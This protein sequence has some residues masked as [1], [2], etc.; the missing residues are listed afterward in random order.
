LQ[1]WQTQVQEDVDEKDNLNIVP[2]EYKPG[3]YA[4]M[5][6]NQQKKGFPEA[7]EDSNDWYESWYKERM[8]NPDFKDVATDRYNAIK[9]RQVPFNL[10]ALPSF[11]ERHGEGKLATAY[12]EKVRDPKNK[13]YENKIY[14]GN[15]IY[16]DEGVND[17]YNE[18]FIDPTTIK[19]YIKKEALHETSHWLENNYPQKGTNRDDIEQD[20][21][22]NIIMPKEYLNPNNENKL[23]NLEDFNGMPEKWNKYVSSPTEIRARLERWR[24]FN[25]ISP[26]KKYSKE[27]M[28]KIIDDNIKEMKDELKGTHLNIMELYKLI[29]KDPKV[30]QQLNEKLVETDKK[31]DSKSFDINPFGIDKTKTG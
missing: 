12:R 26:T 20:K 19:E 18:L 16:P 25:K 5:A 2:Y 9:N 7:V 14:I 4:Q 1:S 17:Y 6:W 28:E 23:Y 8:K 3:S 15:A 31:Q 29:R 24:E 30:L 10:E 11:E 13:P 22:L 21:I 27:E